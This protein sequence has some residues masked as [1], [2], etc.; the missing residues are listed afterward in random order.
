MNEWVVTEKL[1]D[2]LKAK[3]GAKAPKRPRFKI[4]ERYKFSNSVVLLQK[5]H[6]ERYGSN[7]FFIDLILLQIFAESICWNLALAST[8]SSA[9][10]TTWPLGKTTTSST[11][12]SKQSPSS[13]RGS[14]TLAPLF[15]TR[16]ARVSRVD[17]L[18]AS[19]LVSAT[20][21]TV[22]FLII[23]HHMSVQS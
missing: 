14:V 10:A 8:S 21:R 13:S 3:A 5:T 4:G 9:D 11:F 12:S 17:F 19:Q 2:A 22:V 6:P 1:G 16:S 23:R 15:P 20:H 18:S 7:I